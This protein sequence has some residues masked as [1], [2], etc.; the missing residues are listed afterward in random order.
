[1]KFFLQEAVGTPCRKVSPDPLPGTVIAVQT[2][3]NFLGFNPHTYIL[4]PDVCY[5]GNR[6]M[7]RVDDS[8]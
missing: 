8:N 7:L 1:V 4:A 2:F 5:Y 3:G 6:G